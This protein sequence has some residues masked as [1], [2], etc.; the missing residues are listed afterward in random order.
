MKKVLL[1]TLILLLNSSISN[2]KGNFRK[3][4]Y[5][6][7]LAT[8]KKKGQA[9]NF[10]RYLRQAIR[11]RAFIYK[12]TSNYYT[13]RVWTAD[14]V[15]ALRKKLDT[16]KQFH[17]GDFPFVKTDPNKLH[18]FNNTKTR[19]MGKTPKHAKRPKLRLSPEKNIFKLLLTIYIGNGSL[20]KAYVVAKKAYQ[21]FP[22]DPYFLSQLARICM[23]TNKPREAMNYYYKLYKMGKVGFNKVFNLAISLSDFPTAEKLLERESKK[24]SIKSYKEFL[25]VFIQSGDVDEALSILERRC[26]R[27]PNKELLEQLAYVYWDYGSV[28]KAEK[29]LKEIK[30]LYGLSVKDAMLYASVLFSERRYD[31]AY[32]ILR[33]AEEKAKPTDKNYWTT[34]GNMAWMEHNYTEAVKASEILYFHKMATVG[35]Y[36]R[37]I[38]YYSYKNPKKAMRLSLEAFKKFKTFDFLE[39]LIYIAS[40]LKKWQSIVDVVDK[41]KSNYRKKLY[42]NPSLLAAYCTALERIGQRD[43]AKRIFEAELKTH[44]NTNT[45]SQYIYLLIDANDVSTLRNVLRTYSKYQFDLPMPFATAYLY[46]QNGR[47]ALNILKRIKMSKDDY[48]LLLFKADALGLY[49]R[50]NEAN[51]IRFGIFQRMKELVKKNGMPNN[52]EFMENYLRTAMYFESAPNY[53]RLLQKFQDKLPQGIYSDIYTSYLMWLNDDIN[54]EYLIKRYNY[55]ARPWMYLGLGLWNCDGYLMSNALKRYIDI[56]PIRDRVEALRKTG[57]VQKAFEYAF[58]GLNENRQ[59]YLLY[60]QFIDLVVKYANRLRINEQYYDRGN[61]GEILTRFENRLMFSNGYI[62]TIKGNVGLKTYSDLLNTP[63][64]HSYVTL[65]LQK[66]FDKGS[67]NTY[68]GGIKGIGNDILFGLKMK[69]LLPWGINLNIFSDYNREADDTTYLYLGGMKRDLGISVSFPITQRCSFFNSFSHNLYYSQDGNYIGKGESLYSELSYRLRVTY[70]DY[71]LRAFYSLYNYSETD[72]NKG[73]IEK[74]SRYH[75]FKALPDTSSTFGIGYLFGYEN[76]DSLVRVW[77]PFFHGDLTYN[78]QSGL[79][80]DTGVGIGGMAFGN[81]NLAIGLNYIK[82]FKGTGQNPLSLDLKYNLYY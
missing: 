11:N 13:V 79:G 18:V 4:L 7:Q 50:I 32:E 10:K 42:E 24:G 21:Y 22:N 64:H 76:R 31:E 38:S 68:I 47:K 14:T 58:K 5:S 55:T 48:S 37:I 8:F 3:R 77:R 12:T 60:K 1:I 80:F 56:L 67:F 40:D 30:E 44:F 46:L 61:Y 59:D 17:I 72:G 9:E 23:W 66:L 51:K 49:G 53:G 16:L 20:K 27:D 43:V 6:V 54:V 74:F 33:T 70:P 34:L 35:D 29:K 15:N 81:D 71:T 65:N 45:L 73:D 41:L 26:Q 52:T 19:F 75:P 57:N 2:A 39:T 69:H 62:F 78:T 82:G 28:K 63:S 36:Y 25:Y